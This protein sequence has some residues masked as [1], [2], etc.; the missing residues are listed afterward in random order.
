MIR[1]PFA[2]IQIKKGEKK[3]KEKITKK[4]E[5][6]LKKLAA[7]KNN[8]GGI[9]GRIKFDYDDESNSD[10]EIDDNIDFGK[11]IILEEGEFEPIPDMETRSVT[12][13]CGPSGSG[14]S[15]MSSKVIKNYIRMFPKNDVYIF[16]QKDKDPALDD[17]GIRVKLDEDLVNNPINVTEEMK[18]CLVIFDDTDTI[19]NK[20]ISDAVNNIKLQILE[21]G[22]QNNIY[23]IITSHLLNPNDKKS[24]RVILNEFTELIFFPLSGGTHQISYCLTKYLGFKQNKIDELLDTSSRWVLVSKSYPQYIL[25]DKECKLSR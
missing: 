15:V 2:L 3:K 21:L 14:K 4:R 6:M 22:R 17:L 19:P 13:I 20:K 23:C 24:G 18:D 5:Q 25:T 1:K 11:D 12:Y 9:R 7:K 10:D 8:K 16:S